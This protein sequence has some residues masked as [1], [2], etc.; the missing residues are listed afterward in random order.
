M[1]D[2]ATI[3][4][5]YLNVKGVSNCEKNNLPWF[6]AS[7]ALSTFFGRPTRT[8]IVARRA[9]N[10]WDVYKTFPCEVERGCVRE[11]LDT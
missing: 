2:R 4:N 7:T 6:G 11:R 3:W 8:I 10:F 5:G 9:K 1:C